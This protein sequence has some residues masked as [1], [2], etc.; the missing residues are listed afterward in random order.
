[1]LMINTCAYVNCHSKIF[2]RIFKIIKTL[3]IYNN[4]SKT[5]DLDNI[6]K[7]YNRFS[8]IYP[9]TAELWQKYI[10]VEIV[11]AQSPKEIEKVREL[12][13][14]ALQDYYC[15]FIH[16]IKADGMK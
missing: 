16:M 9:L 13:H 7:A 3:Y 10:D 15:K 1:M 11:V 2:F 14:K 5:G 6:R 4:F 8:S 12:F